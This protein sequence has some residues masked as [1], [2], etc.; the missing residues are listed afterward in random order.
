MKRPSTRSPRRRMPYSLGLALLLLRR[1]PALAVRV[2]SSEHLGALASMAVVAVTLIAVDLWPS[3]VE[4]AGRAQA[5][6][7]VSPS[8]ASLRIQF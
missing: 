6:L 5:S 1:A 7:T 4:S 8:R 3:S 2:R